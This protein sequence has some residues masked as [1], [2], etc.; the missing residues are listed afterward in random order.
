MSSQAEPE[1]GHYL[2][3]RES[4]PLLSEP[5]DSTGL[6]DPT[7][8]KS[9]SHRNRLRLRLIVTLFSIILLVETGD[10]MT[11]GPMT[12]IYEAVACQKYYKVLDQSKI[13]PDG[14]VAEELCKIP[15]IQSEVAVVKG[16]G[17]LF[18]GVASILFAIP[19]GVMSDRIGRRLTLLMSFPG[20]LLNVVSSGG[21]LW[22]SNIFPLRAVWLSSLA[23]MFGSGLVASSMVW[24]MIADVTTDTQRSAIF[25]QFGVVMMVADFL[26]NSTASLLMVYNPWYAIVSGWAII[27][28][29]LSL[30]ISLPETKHIALSTLESESWPTPHPSDS[31]AVYEDQGFT[32]PV[33][34]SSSRRLINRISDIIKP[35]SFI[36]EQK[37]VML[38]LWAFV[39]YRLSRGTAWFLIQYVSTRYGWRM[40]AANM[41]ISLKAMLM[42]FLFIV[43][44]PSASWYLTKRYNMS[45]GQ[46]DLLLTKASITSLLIGTLGMGLSPNIAVM[47]LS[48]TVQTLGAGFTYTTRSLI[49]V[50]VQQDQ[51]ARLYTMIEIIQ[52][53]GMVVAS[54]VMTTSFRWGLE[55]GG[56]WQG[57]AWMIAA[58]LFGLAAGLIWSVKLPASILA[59]QN[60]L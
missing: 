50:M 47:I 17:E 29:G 35:Y 52:A 20:L 1:G 34:N 9:V 11:R 56:A 33:E 5:G 37:Q 12:R 48:L 23:L 4:T 28:I 2:T 42:V 55:L 40:A 8:E 49:T 15:P 43:I 36:I 26:S 16:Y 39:V 18:D 38:L 44:L 30:A 57:L 32:K 51:T 10:M 60:A 19:Y 14:Q 24:T 46:K 3:Y 27:S 53:I 58:G 25:F 45:S 22:F 31:R 54:P 59:Q 7:F 6:H 41:L 13:G 21:L